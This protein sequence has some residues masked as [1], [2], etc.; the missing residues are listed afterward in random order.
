MMSDDH[1][2]TVEEPVVDGTDLQNDI[3]EEPVVDGTDHAEARTVETP[4]DVA[5]ARAYAQTRMQEQVE[6]LKEHKQTIA[7]LEREARTMSVPLAAQPAPTPAAQPAPTV[8]AEEDEEDPGYMTRHAFDKRIAQMEANLANTISQT[9]QQR[10][11]A[12]RA[13][14][15]RQTWSDNDI[16]A[17]HVVNGYIKKY[18]IPQKVVD[19]AIQFANKTAIPYGSLKEGIYHADAPLAHQAAIL[20]QFDHHRKLTA[21]KTAAQIQQ[22]KDDSKVADASQVGQPSSSGSSPALSKTENDIR[23]DEI[24]PDDPPVT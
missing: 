15:V 21:K 11:E 18:N 7:D 1:Q 12:A 23:A 9:Q 2:P 5:K 24:A 20:N 3:G 19:D 10:D 17:N 4:E 6:E 13:D 8:A 22:E 14:R 16:Q